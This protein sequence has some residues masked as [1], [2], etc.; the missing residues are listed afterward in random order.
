MN[1]TVQTLHSQMF[2]LPFYNFQYLLN[3][4]SEAGLLIISNIFDLSC[5]WHSLIPFSYA[6]IRIL[7]LAIKRYVMMS[8]LSWGKCLASVDNQYI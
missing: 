3:L 5:W 2:S 6:N 7:Y 8:S 4:L 1:T